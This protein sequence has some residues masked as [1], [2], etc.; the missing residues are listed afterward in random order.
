MPKT[1][2]EQLRAAIA[3]AGVTRYRIAKETGLSE[4]A[5][6]RFVKGTRGMDLNSVDKLATYLGLELVAKD[7]SNPTK[8]QP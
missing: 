1:I 6:S 3:A 5:L 2:T 4:S 7:P 8:V